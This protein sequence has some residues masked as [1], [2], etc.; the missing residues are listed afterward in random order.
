M[1]ELQ[2]GDLVLVRL[3][4]HTSR[5][6]SKWQGPFRIW[7]KVGPMNYEVDWTGSTGPNKF[8]M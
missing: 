1:R 8:T 2:E 6:V 3:L 5:L 4:D 7:R